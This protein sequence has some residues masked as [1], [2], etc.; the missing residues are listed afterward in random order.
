M[1]LPPER[2][3]P[4]GSSSRS[5]TPTSDLRGRLSPQLAEA[6]A[7]VEDAT[8]DLLPDLSEQCARAVAPAGEEDVFL[9]LR[10]HEE[11]S[12]PVL[13]SSPFKDLPSATPQL[14]HVVLALFA[15]QDVFLQDDAAT[16]PEEAIPSAF[17]AIRGAL[18][19]AGS[20]PGLCARAHALTKLYDNMQ[21]TVPD[22]KMQA[23]LLD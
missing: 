6:L 3:S 19:A 16:A 18:A 21:A 9:E 22:D 8:D 4:A 14:D 23:A 10:W 20:P 13:P 2:L 11:D 15:T 1:C 12:G 5:S 17:D 7:A